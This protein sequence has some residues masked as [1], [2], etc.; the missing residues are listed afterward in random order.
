MQTSTEF[1]SPVLDLIKDRRSRRAFSAQPVERERIKS[2][3]EAARWAP[4]STNEQPWHYIY[5]SKAD[6]PELWN[7]IFDALNENNKMWVKDAPLLIMSLFRKKFARNGMPNESARYDLGAANAFLS[8]Q[9]TSFG[10][11]IHQMGGFDHGRAV[12]NLNI[13]EDFDLGV[14]MAVGYDGSP[15]MLSE[16]FR[17]RETAPRVRLIQDEFVSNKSW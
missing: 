3:F 10:L 7:R 14:I 11:N 5:A 9:A 12:S 2:L 15:E 17:Q 4:S 8:L 1:E 6:H 13:P 16:P